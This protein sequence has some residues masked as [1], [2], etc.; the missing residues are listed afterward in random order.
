MSNTTNSKKDYLLYA[1]A[2]TAILLSVVY[3]YKTFVAPFFS[4]ILDKID[5]NTSQ[6]KQYTIGKPFNPKNPNPF[7]GDVPYGHYKNPKNPK[8]FVAPQ[9]KS[10]D[11]YTCKLS[12]NPTCLKSKVDDIGNTF[13]TWD[14]SC[15]EL[16]KKGYRC[17]NHNKQDERLSHQCTKRVC[18]GSVPQ[19]C[20]S[21][22]D[23]NF[24]SL[25][26]DKFGHPLN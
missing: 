13:Y 18:G 2:F 15:D 25:I 5:L 16:P 14:S 23:T 10:L 12:M 20:E 4:S 22:F 3:V 17:F 9:P 11:C 7:S 19:A 24:N 8:S 21:N 26:F 1:L 6:E